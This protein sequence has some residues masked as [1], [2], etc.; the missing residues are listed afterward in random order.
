MTTLFDS[1]RKVKTVRRRAVFGQ[2]VPVSDRRQPYTVSD[3]A[4]WAAASNGPDFD[5]LAGQSAALDSLEA[6][7]C[8]F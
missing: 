6:G 7:I 8:P 2:G 5:Q 4:W 3:L 1:R